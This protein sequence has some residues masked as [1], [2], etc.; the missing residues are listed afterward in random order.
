[1]QLLSF[2]TSEASS[3]GAVI[4]GRVVD[5]GRHLPEYDSLK[6]LLAGNGL[7]RA[8][9]TAAEVSPDYRLDK[10]QLRTPIPNAQQLLCVFDAARDEPVSVDPKFLRGSQRPLRIPEGDTRP[11]AAGVIVAVRETEEGYGALGYMLIGYLSPAILA[12]GPWLTT[13]DELPGDLEFALEV[14]AGE[15][16][17]DL[18]LPDPKPIALDLAQERSLSTGDLVAVLHYLPELSASTEMTVQISTEQLGTLVSP[19]EAQPD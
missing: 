1:V 17:A 6:D 15:Q 9:D 13:P 2:N 5:L 7:V 3:F 8:L 12:A 19:V 14:S 16:K 18:V 11:I 10:I 4:E